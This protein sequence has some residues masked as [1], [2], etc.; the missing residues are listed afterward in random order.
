ML[1]EAVGQVKKKK[2]LKERIAEKEAKRKAEIEERRNKVFFDTVMRIFQFIAVQI[3]ISY[4]R[5]H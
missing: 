5:Q 1:G 3:N 2:P 4:Q